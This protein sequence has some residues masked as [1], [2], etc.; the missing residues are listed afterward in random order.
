MTHVE[1]LL[2]ILLLSPRWHQD[3][4]EAG[5]HARLTTLAIAQVSAAH[6]TPEWK[7][8]PLELVAATAMLGMW[9]SRFSSHVHAGQCARFECDPVSRRGQV[10][11]T[12]ITSWQLKRNAMPEAA[13]LGMIG[14]GLEPTTLAAKEAARRYAVAYRRCRT[15]EGA[16][17]AYALGGRCSGFHQA[18]MRVKS[19][20]LILE[21]LRRRVEGRETEQDRAKLE[22]ALAAL[23]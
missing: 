14:T 8:D 7:R 16:I 10:V 20:D 21:G 5:R 19:Y 1:A 3:T 12:S 13:W 9:E 11:H 6:S 23:D 22:R 17:N 4:H 15:V 18:D 2:A